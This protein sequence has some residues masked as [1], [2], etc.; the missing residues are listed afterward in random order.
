MKIFLNENKF[1]SLLT[2][3]INEYD[4]N[5]GNANKN[6]YNTKIKV[7]KDSLKKLLYT[8][9]TVMT[10]IENGKDYLVYELYSL[11]NTLG[12]RFC[13]CQLLK[14]GEQYGQISTKP[15][16]MFKHKNN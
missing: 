11:A 9:G 16:S 1:A 4:I 15:L 10:S 3:I 6:P 8:N 2:E 14:D 12:K 7:A 13:L 5:D